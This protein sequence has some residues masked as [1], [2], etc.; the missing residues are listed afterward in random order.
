M[1]IIFLGGLIGATAWGT[2]S[3]AQ[4][5]GWSPIENFPTLRTASY[6]M[7]PHEK[8]AYIETVQKTANMVRDGHAQRLVSKTGL[9]LMNLTWEDTGRFKNS[10]IGPNISDMTIQVTVRDGRRVRTELMPVIRFPNF[11]DKTGDIDPS[12]FTLLVGNEDGKPLKRVSLYDFLDDPS[13]YLHDPKSWA[14]RARDK[15][16]LAPRDSKVLV[17]AQACFLPVP[18]SGKATFNPVL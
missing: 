14:G 12:A 16:L 3:M 18:K 1:T 9:Q 7:T 6:V 5:K 8:A 13:R 4:D 11:S 2:A 17:S 15:T 10:A